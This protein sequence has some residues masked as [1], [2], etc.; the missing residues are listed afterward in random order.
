MGFIIASVLVGAFIYGL[1][2]TIRKGSLP[3]SSNDFTPYDDI[4]MGRKRTVND[5]I[6][7]TEEDTR[8]RPSYS[9]SLPDD[10]KKEDT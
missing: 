1:F 9:E 3:S 4:T 7:V 2:Y 10:R 6:Q 8:H 5:H